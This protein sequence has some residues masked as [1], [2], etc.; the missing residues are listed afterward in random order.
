MK[1]IRPDSSLLRVWLVLFLVGSVIMGAFAFGMGTL[2]CW[3]TDC[4]L[5]NPAWF[6]TG[7][8]AFGIFL[9]CWCAPIEIREQQSRREQAIWLHRTHPSLGEYQYHPCTDHWKTTANLPHSQQIILEGSGESPSLGQVQTWERITRDWEQLF[10]VA[11]SA[12]L[13]PPAPCERETAPLTPSRISLMDTGS[14]E[15][16]FRMPEVSD[17]IHMW[18]SAVFSGEFAMVSAAW[19]P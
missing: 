12:L 8:L 1:L 15:A 13:P 11:K 10:A 19:D 16:Q 14:F 9:A 6:V 17:Q 3:L 5:P 4:A 7:A 2:I 18:P